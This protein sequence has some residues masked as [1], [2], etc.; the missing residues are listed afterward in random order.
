MDSVSRSQQKKRAMA[1]EQRNLCFYCQIRMHHD[2]MT[3]EHLVSRSHGGSDKLS[4]LRICH[5]ECN[6][7]IGNLPVSLKLALHDVGVRLG[8]DAFFLTTA[9]LVKLPPGTLALAGIKKRARRLS[10]R[11][12]KNIPPEITRV[13]NRVPQMVAAQALTSN[14][15]ASLH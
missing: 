15:Q 3:W 7:L 13:F 14:G 6:V 11:E 10:K 5:S 1:K 8:S 4:N 12:R 9:E 2:D